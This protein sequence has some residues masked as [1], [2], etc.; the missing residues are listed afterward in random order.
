MVRIWQVSSLI[1]WQELKMMRSD[2]LVGFSPALIS[3][4][5]IPSSYLSV[6]LQS[7]P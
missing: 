3:P 1:F 4:S 5:T 2:S 6:P 7:T